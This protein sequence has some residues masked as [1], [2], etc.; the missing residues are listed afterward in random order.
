MLACLASWLPSSLGLRGQEQDTA[1]ENGLSHT[2]FLS[3]AAAMRHPGAVTEDEQANLLDWLEGTAAHA[4]LGPAHVL[5]HAG[6]R[7]GAPAAMIFRRR[8]LRAQQEQLIS[9][10]VFGAATAG[11]HAER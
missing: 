11:H 2:W 1:V 3:A 6:P 9:Q 8:T 7:P 5:A 10:G 4:Q